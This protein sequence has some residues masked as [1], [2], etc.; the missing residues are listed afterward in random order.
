METFLSF[1]NFSSLFTYLNIIIVGIIVFWAINR[2]SYIVDVVVYALSKTFI[3]IITALV[4]GGFLG[5]KVSFGIGAIFILLILYFILG[6][7]VIK[8]TEKI[9]EYFD[10]DTIIYFIISFALIDSIVTWLF[11]LV[12]SLFIKWQN[13]V[14]NINTLCIIWLK[15]SN[16]RKVFFVWKCINRRI[17]MFRMIQK[18]ML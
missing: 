14:K 16:I 2:F 17:N 11:S 13:I 7:I 8:I 18:E 10:S 5:V 15:W 9:V 12:V 6:L 1:S 4:L 3:P